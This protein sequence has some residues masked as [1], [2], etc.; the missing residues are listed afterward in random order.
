[1]DSLICDKLRSN[2]LGISTRKVYSGKSKAKVNK[3]IFAK[4]G[5]VYRLAG[6]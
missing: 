1:M 4:S 6:N 5:L 3:G 2:R